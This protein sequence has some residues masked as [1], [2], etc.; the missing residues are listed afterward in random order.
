M[1]NP[2]LMIDQIYKYLSENQE[3][4]KVGSEYF[5]SNRKNLS[6]PSSFSSTEKENTEEGK[7]ERCTD[8]FVY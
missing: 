4:M 8:N 1:F 5:C 3:K 7:K 6:Q 2:L